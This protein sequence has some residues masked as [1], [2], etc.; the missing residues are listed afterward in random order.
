MYKDLQELAKTFDKKDW[1][2]SDLR[3]IFAMEDTQIVDETIAC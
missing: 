1:V 2:R 3:L